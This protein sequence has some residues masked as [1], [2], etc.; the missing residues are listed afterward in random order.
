MA[1]CWAICCNSESL[2]LHSKPWWCHENQPCRPPASRRVT[3][4]GPYC[5]PLKSITAG[6]LF[7]EWIPLIVSWIFKTTFLTLLRLHFKDTSSNFL[8]L[9]FTLKFVIWRCYQL[10]WLL[11]IFSHEIFTFL[12]IPK[13]TSLSRRP[14]TQS[15]ILSFLRYGQEWVRTE[16][17]G[18]VTYPTTG[19]V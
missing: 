8:L 2:R 1:D 6:H 19:D 18:R 13:L 16:Q 15:L 10:S 3:D 11:S 5:Y 17:V 12:K 9:S 14:Q 4:T 7:Y